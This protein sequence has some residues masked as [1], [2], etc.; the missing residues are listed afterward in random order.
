[1][2]SPANPYTNSAVNQADPVKLV[3][4]LYSGA[5]RFA[6]VAMRHITA[7]EIEPA[8]HAILR[9]YAIIAELMATLDFEKGGEIAKGLE[10]LYDFML[11]RLKEADMHKQSGPLDE[12][13]SLLVPL[14]GTWCESFGMARPLSVV[15]EASSTADIS[16]AGREVETVGTPIGGRLNLQG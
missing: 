9:C 15:P 2:S 12:V 3:E 13:L 5:I 4:M 8:H 11:S 7:G 1:M 16:H 14:H 10:Q 6:R